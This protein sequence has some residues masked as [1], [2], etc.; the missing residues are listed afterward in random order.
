RAA[1]SSG[2]DRGPPD[3]R[4]RPRQ[5]QLRRVRQGGCRQAREGRG[6]P[7][8]GARMG[9][10]LSQVSAAIADPLEPSSAARPAVSDLVGGIGRG[11]LRALVV[12][13][14]AAL[15]LF[16]VDALWQLGGMLA[17]VLGLFFGGWLLACVVEPIT[18]WLIRRAQL[19]RP[20]AIGATYAAVAA[21]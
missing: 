9:P 8:T 1:A 5:V 2:P 19:R 18:D 20:L 3:A 21:L 12:L 4:P 16:V 6:R 11:W 14:C 17:P 15:G 7:P 13:A 10:V